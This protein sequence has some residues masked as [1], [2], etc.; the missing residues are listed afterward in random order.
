MPIAGIRHVTLLTLLG[1]LTIGA[2]TARASCGA[3]SCALH[4]HWDAQGFTAESGY[5]LDLRYEYLDQNQP[6]HAREKVSPGAIRRHHDELSTLNRNWVG[7]LDYSAGPDWGVAV[8]APLVQRDHRHIH[9]HRGAQIGESWQFDALGDVRVLARRALMRDGATARSLL[10][11]AKLP[12]GDISQR[13]AGGDLAER[14]LQPGSGTTDLLLGIYGQHAWLAGAAAVRHFW[15]VQAQLPAN[16]AGGYRPGNLWSADVGVVYPAGGRVSG[17]VQLNAQVKD[18]DRGPE[19][20]PLDSGGSYVWLSPGVS[21][22][23]GPGAR[24]YG[25]VQLP[26]YQRVNGVQLTANWTATLG[27]NTRF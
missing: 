1:V 4:T 23:A 22:A 25:F 17:L 24:V 10:V 27:V 11:G 21:V 20:E 19:A 15:Q 26:L 6:H 2:T 14:T 12:T 9:N 16:A 7:T 5:G 18:R 13:N 8:Q 3:A